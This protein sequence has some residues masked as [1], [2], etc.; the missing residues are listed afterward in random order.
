MFHRTIEDEILPW[1]AAHDVGVLIYGPL[2]HGLLTG[3][4]TADPTFPDGDWRRDSCDFGGETLR[5][6]LAVV[7]R[8]RAFA[9]QR[10]L[11]LSQL[12]TAWTLANPAVHVAIVG[13]RKADHI[14]A[15][16]DAA[17]VHLDTADLAEIDRILL[18][19][20]PMVGPS[21]EGS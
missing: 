5:R 10:N 3:T 13:A 18:A 20:V 15:A 12:A 11:D 21:P 14:A 6:N 8:L 19:A 4:I 1:T 7:D 16:V 9:A 2:A 17:E